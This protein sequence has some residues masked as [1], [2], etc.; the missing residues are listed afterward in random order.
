MSDEEKVRWLQSY[1]TAEIE[2]NE[3]MEQLTRW[4]ARATK[5]TAAISPVPGG[6]KT[7]DSLQ[8]AVEKICELKAEI[9]AKVTELLKQ[10]AEIK[11]AIC[12]LS[13]K[14]LQI[15]LMKR[16]I[17]GKT[18]ETI[19]EEMNYCI[20]RIFTLHKKALRMINLNPKIKECSENDNKPVI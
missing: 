16:Y 10:Q 4:Q 15:L 12:K 8:K 5:M 1:K 6:G 13:D 14:T 17:D 7:G 20:S 11:Q 18:F 3:L 19:A 9:N 2:I